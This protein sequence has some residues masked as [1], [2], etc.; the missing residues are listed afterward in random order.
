MQCLGMAAVC[1]S[2]T[3]SVLECLSA[4]SSRAFLVHPYIR[5]SVRD[6]CPFPGGLLVCAFPV[7]GNCKG[8]SC[9]HLSFCFACF[10]LGGLFQVSLA[11]S[12]SDAELGRLPALCFLCCLEVWFSQTP[13][14]SIPQDILWLPN[15][16]EHVSLSSQSPALCLRGPPLSGPWAPPRRSLVGLQGPA[17][18]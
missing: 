3:G 10:S 9:S 12:D 14:P 16:W 15:L 7:W 1:I 13:G 6:G 8:L 5:V 11:A 18:H 17:P 4:C 2:Q